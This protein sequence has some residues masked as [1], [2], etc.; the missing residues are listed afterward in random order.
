MSGPQSLQLKLLSVLAL[1]PTALRDYRLDLKPEL[2][3]HP[4]LRAIAALMI[5][6]YDQTHERVSQ[7]LMCH[8]IE[9]KKIKEPEAM[10]AL[11]KQVYSLSAKEADRIYKNY[12]EDIIRHSAYE[13]AFQ[14]GLELF[15]KK[16]YDE[17]DSCFNQ[18]KAVGNNEPCHDAV[19]VTLD[20]IEEALA[21]DAPL[22]GRENLVAT[23]FPTY[24]KHTKGGIG[25]GELHLIVGPPNKGKSRWMLNVGKNAS[26]VGKKVCYISFE[27]VESVCT[28]RY[29]Q[30][31]TGLQIEQ[32]HSK[33]GR[34]LVYKAMSH[35]KQVGG[36]FDVKKF[37]EYAVNFS[38]IES[39]M[40]G[41]GKQYDLI[42]TDYLDLINVSKRTSGNYFVDQTFLY[43]EGRRFG[44]RM[45]AGHLSASQPVDK[46]GEVIV[47]RDASG[48]KG[49]G[50]T[51]DVMASLNAS[52]E[53][54]VA[55][56][57]VGFIGKNRY[58]PVNQFWNM[59][60]KPELIIIREISMS[61]DEIPV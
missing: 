41:Q 29:W 42:I 1:S 47:L 16:K 22:Y 58:G 33:H 38:D 25:L 27:M 35:V 11:V 45:K 12:L 61:K 46:H 19:N 32:L 52:D 2:W 20:D 55:G 4:Q 54:L 7:D 14:R 39:W 30:C 21:D 3:T 18:V 10:I 53:E 36:C 9:R 51:V 57:Q 15:K 50:A 31:C 60:V 49:K 59:E 17:I 26:W 13:S 23:G 5:E 56:K 37:D 48:G 24:D 44:R 40:I 6:I 28:H 43:A 34:S 8:E